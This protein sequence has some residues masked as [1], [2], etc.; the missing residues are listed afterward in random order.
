MGTALRGVP[1][2]GLEAPAG[3]V[4]TGSDWHYADSPAAAEPAEG[5][6]SAPASASDTAASGA[7]R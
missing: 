1:V 4:W 5:A 7:P 6:A 3:V 2:Q